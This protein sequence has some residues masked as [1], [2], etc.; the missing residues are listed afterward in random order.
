MISSSND[1]KPP[2]SPL[3]G[4][5]DSP[6]SPTFS[7]HSPL[8]QTSTPIPSEK[9]DDETTVHEPRSLRFSFSV[10][11]TS[12]QPPQVMLTELLKVLPT[13]ALESTVKKGYLVQCTQH[14]VMFEIE[15][16]KLPRLSVNGVRLKR[17]SGDT[18]AYKALCDDLV[19][20][21]KF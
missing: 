2:H 15:I 9:E 21:L 3:P 13:L 1:L 12:T 10:S 5:Y 19:S 20:K 4:T 8:S 11:T 16:C 14:D 17:L 6:F 18:W 7:S